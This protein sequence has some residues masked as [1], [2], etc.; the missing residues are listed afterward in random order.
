MAKEEG[1]HLHRAAPSDVLRSLLLVAN[2]F[3]CQAS[4]FMAV[5]IRSMAIVCS[6]ASSHWERGSLPI[7][8]CMAFGRFGAFTTTLGTDCKWPLG[9][10][11]H[12]KTYLES[13]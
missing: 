10:P 5:S 4:S 9:L 11:L 7:G 6:L 12:V 8:L 1:M 2:L 13:G 3:G